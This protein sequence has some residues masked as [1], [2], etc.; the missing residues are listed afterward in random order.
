MAEIQSATDPN[1]EALVPNETARRAEL[2][3]RAETSIRMRCKVSDADPH[4]A[5]QFELTGSTMSSALK[6]AVA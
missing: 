6:A 2:A 5:A 4:F 1:G 3:Q